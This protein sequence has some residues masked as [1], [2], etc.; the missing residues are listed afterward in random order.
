MQKL[1]TVVSDFTPRFFQIQLVSSSNLQLVFH[2]DSQIH[3]L[4][5]CS[6]F[7]WITSDSLLFLPHSLTVL[8]YSLVP[9][10]LFIDFHR[11]KKTLA[12]LLIPTI[13]FEL[14]TLSRLRPRPTS[15]C[16]TLLNILKFS[17]T[18]WLGIRK[19]LNK[20]I[21][22]SHTCRSEKA[23]AFNVSKEQ[24]NFGVER[25]LLTDKNIGINK[26]KNRTDW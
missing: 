15:I 26:I 12:I 20:M 8:F 21:L 18:V 23:A 9:L 6:C 14:R 13:V 7:L 24:F 1:P 4:S 16:M 25:F 10:C 22:N 19:Y 2:L 11:V 17:H 3:K 5:S